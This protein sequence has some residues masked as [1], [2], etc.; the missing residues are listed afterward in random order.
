MEQMTFVVF[1]RERKLGAGQ[2]VD[3]SRQLFDQVGEAGHLAHCPADHVPPGLPIYEGLVI[4]WTAYTHIPSR[5]RRVQFLQALRERARSGSPVL[6]SFFTRRAGSLDDKTVYRMA[7]F[8]QFLLRTRKEPVEIGDGLS[9]ARYVHAF[10]RDE[11]EE[12]LHAAGLRVAEYT[13]SEEWGYAM[14]VAD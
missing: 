10:T 1:L 4:G 8:C 5:T 13:D 12:E 2:L 9:Y 7:R 3:A 6:L 14:G 11:L